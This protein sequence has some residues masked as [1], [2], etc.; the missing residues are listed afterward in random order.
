MSVTKLCSKTACGNKD[1]CSSTHIRQSQIETPC[2]RIALV[3]GVRYR[4]FRAT[5]GMISTFVPSLIIK[6]A[7]ASLGYSVVY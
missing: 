3:C 7:V 4:P 2:C 6:V 5:L 1:C